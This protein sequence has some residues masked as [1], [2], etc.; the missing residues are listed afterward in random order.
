MT[1][2]AADYLLIF[3]ESSPERYLVMSEAERRVALQQWNEWCAT[4]AAQG[5]LQEGNPLENVGRV[6]SG[7]RRPALLDGPFA[8]AKELI[9]GYFLITAASLDEATAIAEGCPNLEHGMTIEVRPVA[10]A[11]H[12]ARS[13]GWSTMQGPTATR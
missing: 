5:T 7:A 13:L 1:Q 8:E 12:L 9:G 2:S 6:V 11:C 3:R 4:L 10:G